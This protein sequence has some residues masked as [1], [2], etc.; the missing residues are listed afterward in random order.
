M[1]LLMNSELLKLLKEEQARLK[2]YA[3]EAQERLA[4]APEG[5]LRISSGHGKP[6][7][8]RVTEK[9]DTC[10]A[11]L[12]KDQYFT[13]QALAQKAYDKALLKSITADEKLIDKLVANNASG[14]SLDA[15]FEGL[16]EER[17]KL[18]LPY[19]MSDED[20][21]RI[22]SGGVYTRLEPPEEGKALH[23]SRGEAVRSKSEVII[24]NTL[25][26]LG[27]PYR[28]EQEL[29]LNRTT[30]VHPDF[31]VL[32]LSDRKT[33]I[34]EH[35]GMM[36]DPDYCAKALRKIQSYQRAGYTQ[37]V[38]LIMTIE[39]AAVPLDARAVK[40]LAQELLV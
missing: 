19:E 5:S 16:T 2:K 11:Y 17:K 3:Q 28:Y 14:D 36:D 20:Y 12:N 15:V 31:T 6:R 34:W 4:K 39:S 10:G 23:T 25:A 13:A 40:R 18:V 8:Y 9:H 37:G 32:R 35:F 21:C 1:G 29:Q 26:E 7:Y 38:N 22:W 27:I 24:A 33:I 30:T